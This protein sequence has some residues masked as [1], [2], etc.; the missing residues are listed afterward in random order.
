MNRFALAL[1]LVTTVGCELDEDAIERPKLCVFVAD[2][3][4][5]PEADARCPAS[6]RAF[7]KGQAFYVKHTL[8]EHADVHDPVSITVETACPDSAVTTKHYHDDKHVVLIP[9]VAP[10]GAQ[11]SLIVTATILNETTRYV[12]LPESANCLAECSSSGGEGG[13]N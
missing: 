10:A 3:A 2:A 11:C 9:A 7:T 6:P 5:S 1:T 13:S 12:S 8:P 4:K